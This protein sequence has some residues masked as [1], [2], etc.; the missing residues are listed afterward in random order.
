MVET[1]PKIRKRLVLF[2][3]VVIFLNFLLFLIRWTDTIDYLFLFLTFKT[4]NGES[5][6]FMNLA[7]DYLSTHN[8]GQL[9]EH[10]FFD[11][12]NKF[13][14]PPTSLL[15][16]NILYTIFGRSSKV[17]LFISWFSVILSIL[18][19]IFIFRK[20]GVVLGYIS[21]QWKGNNG[22]NSYFIDNFVLPVLLIL[23][24]LSFYPLLKSFSLGQI[25]SWLNALFAILFYC[26]IR[27]WQEAAGILLGIMCLI[28]PQYLLIALWGIMRRKF[29]F[30]ILFL[31]I[32]V[33]GLFISCLFF[34]IKNHLGY[35][36]VLSFLSL[37]GESFYPNQSMNGL[38]NRLIF[39]GNILEWEPHAFP[40]YNGLVYFGT[41]FFAI[42]LVSAA[43]ILPVKHKKERTIVD[44]A[45]IS[46]VSTMISPI[47]WEHHY[48]I[49]L[50]IYAFLIP[51]SLQREVL[52]KLTLV[53]LWLSYFLSSNF[54]I[55][56]NKFAYKPYLNI[57]LSYLFF[58]AVMVLIYLFLLLPDKDKNNIQVDFRN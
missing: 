30:I 19:S 14:Y 13:Q 1:R 56:F 43:F 23:L 52:G 57:I 22:H 26:W 24:S 48:G 18:F 46:L 28:K 44:F 49:L 25:Q 54:I 40:P 10:I 39:N 7:L 36:K 9:Y 41:I 15:F 17:L 50:P 3:I 29:K 2:F 16:L 5:W 37:H 53:Y 12:K 6:Y 27:N 42:A 32:F 58:A 31:T 35:F 34:G 38:L 20:F 11:G 4:N 47:A 55:I 51:H 45:I 21:K 8:K 33:S